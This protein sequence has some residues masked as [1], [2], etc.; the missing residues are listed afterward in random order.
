ML[1]DV[2]ESNTLCDYHVSLLP[3]TQSRLVYMPHCTTY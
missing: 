3:N 2:L 1:K